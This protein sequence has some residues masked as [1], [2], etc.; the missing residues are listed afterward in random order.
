M[1]VLT[2]ILLS[3]SFESMQVWRRTLSLLGKSV[4]K[5]KTSPDSHSSQ[6]SKDLKA[7]IDG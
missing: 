3:R 4:N 2:C 6:L 7:S 1:E 5:S